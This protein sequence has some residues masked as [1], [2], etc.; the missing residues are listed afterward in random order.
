MDG[1]RGKSLALVLS[2]PSWRVTYYIWDKIAH[3]VLIGFHVSGCKNVIRVTHHGS[4]SR[5][6]AAGHCRLILT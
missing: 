4:A 1:G 6:P 5:P 2:E 3:G